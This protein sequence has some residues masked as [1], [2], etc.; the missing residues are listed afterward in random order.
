[1][2]FNSP[3]YF[4]FLPI[5]FVLYWFSFSKSV[6]NQNILI[7]SYCFYGWWSWKFLILI[8]A[9]TLMNYLYGIGVSSENKK[10]AKLFLKI[11]LINNLG[12]LGIFK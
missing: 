12:I 11:A 6:K 10:K 7:A 2:L 4:I 8:G 9:S 5:V 3:E 1:M